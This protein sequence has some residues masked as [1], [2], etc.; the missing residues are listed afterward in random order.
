M[1]DFFSVVGP[2]SARKI[3]KITDLERKKMNKDLTPDGDYEIFNG[4][5]IVKK[6]VATIHCL[7]K[8]SLLERKISNALLFQAYPNLKNTLVHEI[9]LDRLKRLLNANT[10]NHK[11]L[12]DALRKLI[13]T[14]VEWNVL[15]ENVPELDGWSA[16]TI[17]SSV[18]VQR[19]VVKYQYSELIKSL[20]IDPKIYGKINLIIQSRFKSSYAL[21]LYE[22]CSRYRGLKYTKNFTLSEFRVLM[23]VEEGRYE[24]F[25]DL[26][27][28]V[29]TPAVTEI[30]TCS[31]IRVT[32]DIT[33]KGRKVTAIK[34]VLEERKVKQ[35]IGISG[36]QVADK[37]KE[38]EI[39]E[40]FSM[41]EARVGELYREYGEERVNR[42]VEYVVSRPGYASGNIKNAAGYL[43]KAVE[44]N[45]RV[46]V[47]R[48][49][50]EVV[51]ST[52]EKKGKSQL[53]D[54]KVE[55]FYSYLPAKVHQLFQT[56]P[57]K[58]KDKIEKD[59][60]D[61]G[62]PFHG[63]YVELAIK[64]GTQNYLIFKEGLSN[65]ILKK[66]FGLVGPILTLEAYIDEKT[67]MRLIYE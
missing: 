24:L 64:K 30:N 5:K 33:R 67:S 32:P 12:K 57:D 36:D 48:E 4:R 16:S 49:K 8:L 22:N 19:G 27:R 7:N 62:Q 1:C 28:R 25:R 34:F 31:D 40:K 65:F 9:S 39:A 2:C 23:G 66:Y 50:K 21:A 14:V 29:L 38:K 61:N 43:R 26:N 52:A 11:A 10:R 58:E 54:L 6:H 41:H 47:R 18:S 59:F 20:I 55:Y 63:K 45:F 13:T 53:D 3:C 44:G 37:S 56:L 35:R 60:V 17:L 46:D 42:A 51:E 15:G